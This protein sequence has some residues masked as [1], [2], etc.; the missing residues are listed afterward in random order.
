MSGWNCQTIKQKLSNTLRLNLGN[1]KIISFLH[2]SYHPKI[3][4]N[5]IQKKCACVN[6]I[7]VINGYDS[8]AANEE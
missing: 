4:E 6:D 5:N 2:P 1:L 8:E 3:I 7:I